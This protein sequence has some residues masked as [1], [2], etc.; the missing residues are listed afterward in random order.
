MTRY[1]VWGDVHGEMRRR[2]VREVFCA[3]LEYALAHSLTHISVVCDTFSLCP[4]FSRAAGSCIIWDCPTEYP[5]GVCASILLEVT[6]QRLSEMRARSGIGGP[7]LTFSA[8][9]PP[10]ADRNDDAIA[11]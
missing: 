1:F 11:A 8:L 5:E 7:S 2:A 10:N 3:T 4:D 9:P 6:P